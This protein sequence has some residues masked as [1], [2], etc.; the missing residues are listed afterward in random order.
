[1]INAMNA[2]VDQVKYRLVQSS[3]ARQRGRVDVRGHRRHHPSLPDRRT[4]HQVAANHRLSKFR[5]PGFEP[6]TSGQ[7]HLDADQPRPPAHR[8]SS[9]PESDRK[10]SKPDFIG[11]CSSLDP[12]RLPSGLTH[13]EHRRRVQDP[14][15]FGLSKSIM[16]TI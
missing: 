4:A 15:L 16:G 1:M 11:I 6:A 10:I 9:R 14:E 13:N 2:R 7:N 12:N 8:V 3:T 5:R